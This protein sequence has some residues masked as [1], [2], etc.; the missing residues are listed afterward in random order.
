MAQAILET[1][2]TSGGEF[3][4]SRP[5]LKIALLTYEG[6]DMLPSLA[7]E[8]P[9]HDIELNKENVILLIQ[10]LTKLL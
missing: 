1:T 4:Q 6:T 10:A 5:E 7:F 8:R 2:V 3:L 9:V